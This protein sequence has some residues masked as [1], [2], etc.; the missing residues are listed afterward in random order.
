MRKDEGKRTIIN[1]VLYHKRRYIV[2]F[3]RFLEFVNR[4]DRPRVIP[5]LIGEIYRRLRILVRG[6]KW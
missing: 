4:S 2:S 6:C 1:L 3:L 5:S